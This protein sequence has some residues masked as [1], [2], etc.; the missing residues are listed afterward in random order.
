[1]KEILIIEDDMAISHMLAD[2]LATL[3][4]A[5]RQAANGRVGLEMLQNK[6]PDL[7]LCD[8]MMPILDGR[9]VCQEIQATPRY[10]SIPLVMMSAGK[11]DLSE[12]TFTAFLP[13]PFDVPT[14]F[15]LVSR[16]I[17]SD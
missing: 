4:Y 10:Q 13:K 8:V 15:A 9:A 17:D 1:M 6:L 2:L 5:V 12:C 11:I 3:D 14:L 7:I 16:L